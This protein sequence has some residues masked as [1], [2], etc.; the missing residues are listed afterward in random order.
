MTPPK[1]FTSSVPAPLPDLR[2]AAA[3]I[4]VSTDEQVEL[5]PASQLVEIRKWAARNGYIVPDEFVF[6][7]EGISGRGVK[8]RDEFRRMIGVA[9]SKPKPFDAILLWKFSR[10]ARNR[11][12][13]VMYKSI[14]RKQLGID[15]IS[16]SEPV[17]EGGMGLITE[18]LIE[19]MDEYYSINLAQEVKRGM[20]EKHRR[21]EVQCAPPYGYGLKD[22]VY[23]PKPPED[24]YVREIFRRYLAG[25]GFFPLARWLN[26]CGQRTHRGGKFENRT[27]E[28]ILRN[29]VY[30]GKLRWN[31][32]GRTRR[33]Y[34][35]EN[36]VLSDGKHVPL[37]DEETFNAVQRRID[38]QKLLYP[39]Y[40]RQSWTQKHWVSGLVHC[41][42]C[43]G[44]LVVNTPEHLVCKNYIHGSC[45]VRQSIRRDVLEDALLSRFREDAAR[46][47]S[48]EFEVVRSGD[49]GVSA[50]AALE[51]SR[52]S[53]ARMLDRLRDA[54]LTGADTVEE[55]KASKAAVQQRI[56]DLDAQ[57]A[58]MQK[59]DRAAADPKLL[60]S[61][62]RSVVKTLQSPDATVAEK[63]AA[64]RS[65][66]ENIT[67]NK[68][69]NTLTVH[70]RLVL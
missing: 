8:K 44:S 17:A 40:S 51:A 43:G 42:A 20:E 24:D 62:L 28:Y 9:K 35:N 21:G 27:V 4:R 65:V 61:A 41:A 7:D 63:N 49:N 14:L 60:R 68:A 6:M 11:D 67:W 12:D 55:Y 3:Y 22:H 34:A 5:S 47:S 29:P 46:G 10:F 25:E 53:A 13:A 59:E 2:I 30:I 54:Y 1:G 19:A 32:A 23:V 39:K 16:I 26:S 57:I 15:V 70:Y 66:A 33:D 48:P 56:A 18:A 37:I 38:E 50:M 31:P 45:L 58:V 69:A 64:V 36:V 52:D